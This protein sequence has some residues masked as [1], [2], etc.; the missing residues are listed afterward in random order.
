MVESDSLTENYNFLFYL[1][2]NMDIVKDPKMMAV[3]RNGS[4]MGI[5]PHLLISNDVFRDMKERA[6]DLV[7]AVDT[8]YTLQNGSIF[9]RAKDFALEELVVHDK[10]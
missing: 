3:L 1:N 10:R 4:M 6:T 5:F 7:N 8:I 2:S 9:K